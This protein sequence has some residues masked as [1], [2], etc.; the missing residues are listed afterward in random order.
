[1]VLVLGASS[2]HRALKTLPYKKRKNLLIRTR[3][4]SGLSFNPNNSNNTKLQ[5]LR[6]HGCLRNERQI[7]IWHDI[8][9]NS[10][11]TH[12]KN[13]NTKCSPEQLVNIVREFEPQIVG[14]L[15]CRRV[16]TPFIFSTLRKLDILVVDVLKKFISK[17][18]QHNLDFVLDLSQEHLKHKTEIHLLKKVRKAR[19][20]LKDLVRQQRSK[21][22][23]PLK[24][25]QRQAKR[26]KEQS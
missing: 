16:G 1:M 25:K 3:S 23:V 11:T 2:L 13:S 20:D 9:N 4:I 21:V 6:R 22:R 19:Y 12:R 15:Y 10:L 26:K 5:W 18:L 8:I 14:I 24:K 17:K 7:I